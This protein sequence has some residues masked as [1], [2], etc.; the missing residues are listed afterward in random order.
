MAKQGIYYNLVI[1][2]QTISV[3]GKEKSKT[4]GRSKS[5]DKLEEIDL[6][7][8][9]LDEDSGKKKVNFYFILCKLTVFQL[10]YQ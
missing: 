3:D 9:K 2:Q 10:K 4:K 8:A 7:K 5:K 1:S 6:G